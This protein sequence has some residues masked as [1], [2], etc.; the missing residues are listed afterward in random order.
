MK[1]RARSASVFIH[2]FRVF[3]YPGET[4][5]SCLYGFSNESRR[6]R[7]FSFADLNRIPK[8]AYRN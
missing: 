7:M 8:E 3:G 4:Q 5:A 6:N 1:T 2:C